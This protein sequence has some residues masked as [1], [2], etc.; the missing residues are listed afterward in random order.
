[1][2]DLDKTREEFKCFKKGKVTVNLKISFHPLPPPCDFSAV[3]GAMASP[4]PDNLFC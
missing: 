4:P 3:L 1:M 2:L